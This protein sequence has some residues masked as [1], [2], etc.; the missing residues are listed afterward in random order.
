MAL[1]AYPGGG[2]DVVRISKDM[3]LQVDV[4]RP[5]DYVITVSNV[6]LFNVANIRVT[7]MLP[8]GMKFVSA[9]PHPEIEGNTLVWTLSSLEGQESKDINVTLTPTRTDCNKTCATMTY[10]MPACANI[11]VVQ[12]ALEISKTAPEEVMVCDEIPMEIV[13]TNI[14]TGTVRDVIVDVPLGHGITS[15]ENKNELFFNVGSL[16]PG[17]SR[18]VEAIT[19]PSLTGEFT[20]EATAKA[21]GGLIVSAVS[22]TKVTQPVL[23]I[24]SSSPDLRYIGRSVGGEYTVANIG[25]TVALDTMINAKLPIGIQDVSASHGGIIQGDSATWSLGSL[26]PG[27]FQ[28]VSIDFLATGAGDYAQTATATAYCAEDVTTE[29]QTLVKGIPAI[30]LEVVDISDPIEIG[31]NTTYV[32]TATNQGS[33]TATNIRIACG[34]EEELEFVSATGPSE[35]SHTNGVVVFEALETLEPQ[36]QAAWRVTVRAVG[37]GDIRFKAV[38]NT[39]QLGREVME[40]EATHLYE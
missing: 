32:I 26:E 6:A 28:V 5:F 22:R 7:E 39:D 34:L 10:D 27:E 21:G 16:E 1:T 18:Q 23:T 20:H 37:I 25:D 13:V 11:S 4:N 8:E 15:V 33:K 3:P 38:M 30:L 40:T 14:G 9:D 31:T 35:I 2:S 12:P 24:T 36:A 19:Q 17:E 29:T